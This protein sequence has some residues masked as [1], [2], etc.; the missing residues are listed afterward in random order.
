M[1]GSPVAIEAYDSRW[2]FWG[3]SYDDVQYLTA[4]GGG[5][6]SFDFGNDGVNIVGGASVIAAWATPDNNV[7]LFRVAFAPFLAMAIGRSDFVGAIKPNG[8]VNVRLSLPQ[9]G[10]VAVGHGVG[11]Y[12]RTD[13]QATFADRDG[14]PYQLAG[15][16][17]LSAPALGDHWQVP[18]VNGHANVAADSVSGTCF[19]NHHYAVIVFGSSF[20]FGFALGDADSSGHFTVDLSD[21]LNI[22]KGDEVIIGCWTAAGDEVDQDFLAGSNAAATHSRLGLIRPA[23]QAGLPR[24][25]LGS[26][27]Q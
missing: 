11:S 19:A 13:F 16:E 2:D 9:R 10:P 20:E 1:A 7:Q 5:N 15:G 3:E 25:K 12:S 27:R 21:Q 18:D 4:D 17:W 23:H 6:Y 22:K 14:N 24:T 8:L 26:P